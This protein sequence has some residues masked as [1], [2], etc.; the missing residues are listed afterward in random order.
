[1]KYLDDNGLLYLWGKL[2]AYFVSAISYD[3]TN[4][5]IKVTK[6]G[7]TTDLVTAATIVSD[8]GG[9]TD[10]SGKA[11][12]VSGAT[13]GNFAGLDSNGNLVDSGHKHSDYLTSHQDI[14]GKAD[15]VSGAT[16]GNF[17]GLDSNGNLTDSGHKHSDYLTEH[18]SLSNY[19]TKSEVD[20]KVASAYKPAGSAASL[21]ELGALT[22]ANEG[23]LYDMSASFT[24]TSD[25]KDYASQGAK[26]FPAGTQVVII[27]TAASG[28]TAVYK[29][30]TLSGLQDLSGYVEASDLVAITNAEIDTIVAS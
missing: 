12:K 5:K 19:Y 7:S 16:N 13:N 9:V 24:T 22:A 14:S 27:N 25:F 11:D 1:M 23:K 21:S 4:K 3:T 29:Y 15:K 20:A 18:Q 30:D 10:V 26:T 6:N 17:A 2:K 28:E 8:G